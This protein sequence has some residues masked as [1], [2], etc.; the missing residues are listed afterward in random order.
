MSATY[1]FAAPKNQVW[2]LLIDPAVIGTCLPG[3]ESMEQI[4]P[5]RYK[6]TI[7][8]RIAAITGKY[9]GTVEM[10]DKHKPK[11]ATHLWLKARETGVRK[12]VSDR[13]AG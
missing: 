4:G 3:C 5:D 12:R 6:A 1:T 11:V 13:F 9:E 2:G 10:T 8:I 7:T